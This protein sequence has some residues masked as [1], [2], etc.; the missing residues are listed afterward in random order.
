MNFEKEEF[1]VIYSDNRR[2]EF[3]NIFRAKELFLY[4]P[5]GCMF[6]GRRKG[7]FKSTFL[8]IDLSS[9]YLE[10]RTILFLNNTEK[11]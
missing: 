4:S 8:F 1:F 11:V 6:V 3:G 7:Y 10:I 2:L 5:K 9:E